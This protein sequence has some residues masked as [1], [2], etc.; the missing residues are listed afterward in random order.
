LPPLR[1]SSGF[2]LPYRAQPADCRPCQVPDSFGL[3]RVIAPGDNLLEVGY[4]VV[5]GCNGHTLLA[6][7]PPLLRMWQ[8]STCLDRYSPAPDQAAPHPIAEDSADCLQDSGPEFITQEQQTGSRLD[9]RHAKTTSP[10]HGW[11]SMSHHGRSPCLHPHQHV[12][13]IPGALQ[14]EP[15]RVARVGLTVISGI[16]QTKARGSGRQQATDLLMC[17]D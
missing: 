14:P 7:N 2:P 16:G 1:R 15:D 13:T 10:T 3:A 6:A 11:V 12:V 8:K 9:A 5:V 4:E 17:N